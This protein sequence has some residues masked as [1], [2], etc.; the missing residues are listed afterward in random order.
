VVIQRKSGKGSSSSSSFAC[1]EVE[2]GGEGGVEV[3]VSES[4]QVESKLDAESEMMG[5]S[6][7]RDWTAVFVR[8]VSLE[9]K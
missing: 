7:G 9:L 5:E 4:D 3:E 6:I 1:S 8:L 2:R